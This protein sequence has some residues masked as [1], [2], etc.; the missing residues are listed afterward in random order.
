MGFQIW[1]AL[2]TN[3][4]EAECSR[5]MGSGRRVAVA[6]RS[7]VNARDLQ[8]KYAKVLYE[9]LLVPVLIYGIET[10]LWKQREIRIRAV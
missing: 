8:L 5:K 9:I 10:M 2:S 7:L 6:I 3:T 4:E 1:N